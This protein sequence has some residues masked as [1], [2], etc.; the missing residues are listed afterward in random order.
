[1]FLVPSFFPSI[2]YVSD[3]FRGV[4]LWSPLF[5]LFSPRAQVPPPPPT[6]CTGTSLTSSSFVR[7]HKCK[8]A[9]PAG[10]ARLLLTHS[11]E[12]LNQWLP[13]V[14]LCLCLWTSKVY[15][16]PCF[17][18]LNLVSDYLLAFTDA[19]SGPFAGIVYFWC[20]W[21]WYPGWICFSLCSL[22]FR[23]YQPQFLFFWNT[24][25]FF[26]AKCWIWREA[27]LIRAQILHT[28][29]VLGHKHFTIKTTNAECF[30]N[31]WAG[32]IVSARHF[33]CAEVFWGPFVRY[34]FFSVQT[35]TQTPQPPHLHPTPF[36]TFDCFLPPR[37]VL[38][39][40]SK[41][42]LFALWFPLFFLSSLQHWT[43]RFSCLFLC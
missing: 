27:H 5:V 19:H 42:F 8:R 33:S 17:A 12:G 2:W 38:P 40:T 7:S 26:S 43:N 1:M 37:F 3:F 25:A 31:Y 34:H 13:F 23:R 24:S 9:L 18:P 28:L 21:F 15:Q 14:S 35:I 11:H 41:A 16:M 4:G 32:W 20:T 39:E 6:N 30:K 10:D 22:L 36:S 29:L